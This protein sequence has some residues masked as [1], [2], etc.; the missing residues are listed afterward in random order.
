MV[1][2]PHPRVL[3]RAEPGE[4]QCLHC[5]SQTPVSGLEM[6]P[7]GTGAPTGF[8]HRAAKSPPAVADPSLPA[9]LGLALFL[10]SCPSWFP[11]FPCTACSLQGLS[12]G[13]RC[14]SALSKRMVLRVATS[15]MFPG[16]GVYVLLDESCTERKSLCAIPAA[17]SPCMSPACK[18]CSKCSPREFRLGL[19]LARCSWEAGSLLLRTN[20]Y[21]RR[22]HQGYLN[23][24]RKSDLCDLHQLTMLWDFGGLGFCTT[25]PNCRSGR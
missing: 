24:V 20:I 25:L 9:S 23:P 19:S 10:G 11:C 5:Q 1:P 7:P 18:C 4:L 2:S 15:S 13:H 22:P 3:G 16:H 8:K 6:L 21:P 14:G 12:K 17:E